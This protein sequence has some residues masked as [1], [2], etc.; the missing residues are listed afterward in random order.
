MLFG[1]KD[2]A[3]MQIVS[4]LTSK[5]V[6][7]CNYAKTS[8]IDFTSDSVYAYN[9]TTKAIRWDKNREG[10][11]KTEMEIFET[12]MIALLFG[13]SIASTSMSI[14]K[15]EVIAVQSGGAGAS[16]LVA[17]IPGSLTIFK[18]DS[19]MVS[20]SK[21]Q[22]AGVPATAPDTYSI[23]EL[24]LTLSATTF[25]SAG[26]IVAYYLVNSASSNFTVNNANFPG[27][28]KIYADSAIRGTDQIDKFVQ[29]QLLNVKP[30][31]N[32]TLTM[33]ADNVTKLSIEWDVLAD[34]SGNMMHYVEV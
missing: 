24:A 4:Q 6:I 21:E 14:A 18:L 7:Y 20:Q 22:I 12:K 10:T 11:F 2:A 26:Y 33:D 5:P 19:D 29:Y 34:S 8:T 27:G 16:L 28:Y 1:I 13:T 15:R 23:A 9:K 30:K 32:V 3:N 25:A 17:P 31:S